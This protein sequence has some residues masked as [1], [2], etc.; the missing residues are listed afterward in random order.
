MLST[1]QYLAHSNC[2]RNF[3]DLFIKSNYPLRHKEPL[4]LLEPQFPDRSVRN[5]YL[6]WLSYG[7]VRPNE[8]RQKHSKHRKAGG[9]IISDGVG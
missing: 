1:A 2:S 5:E 4:K 3:S 9:Y 6:L 7:V 8:V